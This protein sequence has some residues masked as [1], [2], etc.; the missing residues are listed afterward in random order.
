MIGEIE[1]LEAVPLAEAEL[2]GD[3]AYVRN[4]KAQLINCFLLMKSAQ[5]DVQVEPAF[6]LAARWP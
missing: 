2:T 5:A 6:R 1:R 3:G 4:H